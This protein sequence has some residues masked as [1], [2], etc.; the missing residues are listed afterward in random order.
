MAKSSFVGEVTC[1]FC[2]PF[3][4]QVRGRHSAGEEFQSLTER[5]KELQLTRRHYDIQ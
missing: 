4:S 1:K 5:D 3:R 2:K